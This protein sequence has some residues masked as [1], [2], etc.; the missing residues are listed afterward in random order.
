MRRWSAKGGYR[1]ALKIGLPLVVSML[2]TTVMT[3]TDR[4]FLGGYSLE[5][6]SA[7][8]PASITA[9]LFLCFCM[10][11]VEYA[12][13][14]V[15]QY[16]GAAQPHKVGR[17]MWQGV[18]FCVPAGLILAGFWFLAEPIFILGGHPPEIMRLEVVYFR[19]L[20]LGG[21]PFLLGLSLSCFFSGRGLTK[22]VMVVTMVGTI[23]NIPLDYCLI[24]GIGPFPELGIAGAGI[25]T[26][27]GYSLPVLMYVRLVF[28]AENERTYRV[29]SDWRL[30]RDL[31]RR[32]MRF[33][34]PG[35][36]EFFLDTF[37]VSF[38]VFMIGRFGE[39]ELASTSAVF[40]IYNLAFLPI[41]GLNIATSIMVGQAMGERNVAQASYST[42][43]V[44]HL[45]IG[46]MAV[47]AALF[48]FFPELL[49]NLFRPRGE[50]ANN[51]SA[52]V[53]MGVV[54]MRY[55]AAFTL[56]DAVAIIYVGGLKGAGDSRFTM[57]IFG[58]AS[59][60]CMIG[61]IVGLSMLGVRNIHGPW[62]C[63]LV[64]VLFLATAF[65]VRFRKGPW[66]RI[67]MIGKRSP[68]KYVEPPGAVG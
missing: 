37:A 23:I 9:F 59:M 56:I 48:V 11:V 10:G 67:E 51:F 30:D 28:T 16:T 61:P 49:L 27:I 25:A 26:V 33:G 34:V 68:A 18:W 8:V 60:V 20:S 63:L 55:A 36:V 22:P 66:Q 65:I 43:S 42:Q 31:F 32:F 46:Y 35:G 14:F 12:G 5:A 47:M 44:F 39:V 15:A 21:L 13:V 24:Y 52:V 62:L 17:A 40:S 54:L 6:L 64:Y 53:D 1:E 58:V 45:A 19:I 2:S 38:F 41:I 3:F 4:I 50:S 7:S 57:V 29:R